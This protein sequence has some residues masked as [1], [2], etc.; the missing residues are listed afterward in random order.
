MANEEK[1]LDNEL[2]KTYNHV[3][4]YFN[5]NKKEIKYIINYFIKIII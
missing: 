5:N 1:Q 4:N 2:I 3:S